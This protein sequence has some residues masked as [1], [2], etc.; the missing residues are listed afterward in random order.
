MT[1]RMEKFLLFL[2]V[3]CTAGLRLF[4]QME[5]Q[6]LHPEQ[7]QE[8]LFGFLQDLILKSGAEEH[9]VGR[10]LKSKLFLKKSREA[11]T[12]ALISFCRGTNR[13]SPPN[14]IRCQ[15]SYNSTYL[16]LKV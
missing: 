8:G 3:C 12:R 15:E 4:L 5:K 16:H 14:I 7:R 13:K 9:K 6:H 10:K 2:L 11:V 1:D